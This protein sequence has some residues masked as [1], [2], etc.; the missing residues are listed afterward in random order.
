VSKFPASEKSF[1]LDVKQ[2]YTARYFL[3]NL[4]NIGKFS[5]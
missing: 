5:S 4:L 1:S 2:A 3:A